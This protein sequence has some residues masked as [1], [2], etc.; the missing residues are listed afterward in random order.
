MM[1]GFN[2]WL[3]V[4]MGSAAVVVGVESFFSTGGGWSRIYFGWWWVL[5]DLFWAVVGD[6]IV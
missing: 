4:V 2:A 5:V 6:Y 1:V 3:W